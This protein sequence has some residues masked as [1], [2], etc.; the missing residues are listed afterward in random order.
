MDF[1]T[2][3]V[4]G[5]VLYDYVKSGV[6]LTGDVVKA[7]LKDYFFPDDQVAELVAQELQKPEYQQAESKEALTGLIE[8]NTMLIDAINKMNEAPTTV[9]N[10]NHHGI[11]DAFGGDK[12]MGDKVMGDKRSKE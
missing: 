10:I 8:Q 4:L 9:Y 2:S 1:V 7:V 3:A 5:G 11:G 6:K 12:V